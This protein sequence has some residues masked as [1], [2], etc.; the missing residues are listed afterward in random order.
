MNTPRL[1]RQHDHFVGRFEAMA[2]ECQ[3]LVRTA[4]ASLASRLLD[5]AALRTRAIE[6]KYSRYLPDNLCARINHSRGAP[7]PIDDETCRLLSFADTCYRLSGGLFDLTSGV[8]RQLWHFDGTGRV[9]QQTEIDALLPR[10]GWEKLQWNRDWVVLPPGMEL[11]FGG[12]GKEY[13][14]DCVA[15]LMAELTSQP[16]LVN[17]GGDLALSR[18]VSSPWRIGLSQGR[19]C[20]GPVHVIE[21]YQGALATSGDTERFIDHQG[22]RY[23]HLLNPKTGWATAGGPSQLTVAGGSCL[24]AGLLSTLS[25]LHGSDAEAY[26]Q[27]Q[28][29]PYWLTP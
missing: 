7:V 6:A 12:I 15:A 10:I 27:A 20:N 25:L 13:A 19:R 11:D 9:P 26:I 4:D 29:V 23:S 2:C 3:I 18:P 5:A 16:T 21:V 17:F 8:L 28:N 24:Q 1:S 22:R 14:V